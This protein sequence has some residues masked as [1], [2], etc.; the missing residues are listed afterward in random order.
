MVGHTPPAGY[1]QLNGHY[2]GFLGDVL[3]GRDRGLD[4]Q[5]IKLY[6]ASVAHRSPTS[7][8]R[9]SRVHQLAKLYHK[10]G[11]DQEAIDLLYGLV[12]RERNTDEY[13]ENTFGDPGQV[14]LNHE[15]IWDLR[16]AVS[17]LNDIGYPLDSL[18]LLSR[19][20]FEQRRAAGVYKGGGW[21]YNDKNVDQATNQSQK[22]L[23]TNAIVESLDRGV[24]PIGLASSINRKTGEIDNPIVQLLAQLAR[25][26]LTDEAVAAFESVNAK[27]ADVDAMDQH[28]VGLM[29]QHPADTDIA[30][31]ATLFAFLCDDI[32]KATERIEVLDSLTVTKHKSCA[33]DV[34]LYL[35]ASNGVLHQRTAKLGRRL[36]KRAFQSGK[37]MNAEWKKFFQ[38]NRL[39]NIDVSRRGQPIHSLQWSAD[40]TRIAT[41]SHDGLICIWTND[42]Q[43][44]S[45]TITKPLNSPIVVFTKK[46]DRVAVVAAKDVVPLVRREGGGKAIVYSLPDGKVVSQFDCR[47]PRNHSAADNSEIYSVV[48]SPDEKQLVVAGSDE[49]TGRGI[50]TR[51]GLVSFWEVETGKK[52][53]SSNEPNHPATALAYSEDGKL[54]AIGTSGWSG[55]GEQAG[56]ILVWHTPDEHR[57][58]LHS[59]F[60][61]PFAIGSP[62]FAEILAVK[63]LR[64][65]GPKLIARIRKGNQDGVGSWDLKTGRIDMNL[66]QPNSGQVY[67]MSQQGKLLAIVEDQTAT[68]YNASSSDEISAV[69]LPQAL[70]VVS[71]N[72]AGTV[73]GVGSESGEVQLIEIAAGKP[74]EAKKNAPVKKGT[75]GF[76]LL[77]TG[78][79]IPGVTSDKGWQLSESGKGPL[80]YVHTRPVFE[81]TRDKIEKFK[82]SPVV[83]ITLTQ[84]AA[85]ELSQAMK[86]AKASSTQWFVMMMNGEKLNGKWNV[87]AFMNRKEI[88]VFSNKVAEQF[89][90]KPQ[91]KGPA[92]GPATSANAQ[93]RSLK[94]FILAGQ[95]N[96]VGHGKVDNGRNPDYDKS[97]KGSSREIRGGIG[98]LRHMAT[99]PATAEKFG[100]LL[101]ADGSWAERDDVFIYSTA[102]GKDKGRM[103]VGFG[104]GNWFGPELGF[105]NIV[106]DHFEEPVLIIKTAWGGK[107]LAV[108]FRPPS[109]GDT[110][111]KKDREA[112]A[113]Y[114]K[115]MSI[116]KDRLA[117]CESDFPELRGCKPE[118]VGFGWHQGWND[119]CSKAMTAEY[120]QNMV[121]FISDVRK[122]LGVADLPFVI[123]NTGQNGAETKGT[124]ATLCEK[125]MS[126]GNP[127]KHPEFKGTVTSIDTRPFK[128]PEERSPS[129]FGYHWN[130]SGETHYRVGDS[131]GKAMVKLLH[132]QAGTH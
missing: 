105:G 36:A 47:A 124:F 60:D 23:N 110:D 125:Q 123:A 16:T 111:L 84:A 13:M 20:T 54:L 120:E 68:I 104:K 80:S 101:N 19:V 24:I 78:K 103:S 9:K 46:L 106:G 33:A 14:N 81:I 83:K 38:E 82:T 56:E 43:K 94:V 55:E 63:Q 41:V 75:I 73:V 48:F 112:G 35:A 100:H 29:K 27:L 51:R 109:S 97:V 115:M 10:F 1:Q 96:M 32:E 72:P 121:N 2:A 59:R 76:H 52:I 79:P 122:E 18:S 95:S 58:Q 89:E 15:R 85:A 102:P 113:F 132:Y 69:Q 31:A 126:I 44:L 131:M 65:A 62:E 12:E 127:E 128:A 118:I 98:S 93:T 53:R 114:R 119:G 117:N 39:D 57:P 30:V 90:L 67:G 87:T 4:E 92:K 70:T 5:V 108:D 77:A 25:K 28:L 42:G 130:H 61:A 11:R 8:Y 88:I 34:S 74:K 66:M 26:E 64:F 50:A 40:G 99:N 21:E 129:G 49:S 45:E 17:T 86:E 7:P 91:P 37:D 107:D 6:E 116:V 3:A 22:L 71:F